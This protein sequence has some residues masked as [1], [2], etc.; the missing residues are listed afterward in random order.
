[1]EQPQEWPPTGPV[2]PKQ[3]AKR[4]EVTPQD[5]LYHIRQKHIAAERPGGRDY[6]IAADE[7]VRVV[8]LYRRHA[9]RVWQ[10]RPAEEEAKGA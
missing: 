1:M 6:L 7:A 8:G 2:T 4:L 10:A 3:L 5:V 9:Q